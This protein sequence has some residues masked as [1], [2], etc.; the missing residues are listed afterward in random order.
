MEECGRCRDYRVQLENARTALVLADKHH[1]KISKAREVFVQRLADQIRLPL[2]A[3]Q[4]ICA[5]F[6]RSPGAS[7]AAVSQM[8]TVCQTTNE[9]LTTINDLLQV[10]TIESGRWCME[11]VAFQPR[12]L[13]DLILR[14]LDHY[15]A[16]KKLS[17]HLTVDE[18]LPG[19]MAGDV[20]R[21]RQLLLTLYEILVEKAVTRE[22]ISVELRPLDEDDPLLEQM[23][24]SKRFVA[25]RFDLVLMRRGRLQ[26]EPLDSG[27]DQDPRL[28]L[29]GDLA[30]GLGGRLTHCAKIGAFRLVTH[31]KE[32]KENPNAP[33]QR[34]SSSR[35]LIGRNRKFSLLLIEE[36]PIF[37]KSFCRNLALRGHAIDIVRDVTEFMAMAE[38]GS[39]HRTYDC[40][41]VDMSE[42]NLD[43]I[44]KLRKTERRTGL[45][46]LPVLVSVPYGAEGWE[47]RY[48]DAVI[49]GHF[50]KPCSE[51]V[52]LSRVT[53]A[54]SSVSAL[55]AIY[56]DSAS[57]GSLAD[58]FSMSDK[59]SITRTAV[60]KTASSMTS[61]TQ[62]SGPE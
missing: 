62:P 54:I 24:R 51:D 48:L 25:C 17:F 12:K 1:D 59:G 20:S 40:V 2:H 42:A 13:L 35:D 34:Y 3:V 55:V 38:A 39:I 26:L 8:T 15:V 44:Q 28:V 10:A 45:K 5:S 37:L 43:L 23:P 50:M 14:L 22:I 30:D 53:N 21:L 47:R 52:I 41:L 58:G 7:E 6:G 16:A 4:D 57:Q 32:T 36:N 18:S 19:A 33:S 56:K 46:R 29:A 9:I 11:N 61:R 31:F 60:E 49:D 27:P